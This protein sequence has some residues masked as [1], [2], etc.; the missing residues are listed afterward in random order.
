MEIEL[1]LRTT[2]VLHTHVHFAVLD[3]NVPMN[4]KVFLIIILYF[5]CAEF[6]WIGKR[7][8]LLVLFLIDLVLFLSCLQC[9]TTFHFFCGKVL[10]HF[11]FNLKILGRQQDYELISWFANWFFLNLII[12]SFTHWLIHSWLKMKTRAQ[13]LVEQKWFLSELSSQG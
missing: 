7:L 2:S 13:F 11:F 3:L 10:N 4:T 12:P 9:Q 1:D 8:S 5:G 6:N